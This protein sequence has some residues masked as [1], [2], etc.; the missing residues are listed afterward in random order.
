MVAYADLH[1]G[2]KGAV[3]FQYRKNAAVER[4]LACRNVY[5]TAL[6]IFA[7]GDFL[8]PRLDVFK[9]NSDVG[10]KLFPLGSQLHTSV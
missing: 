1:L 8:L 6:E 7:A 2:I 9:G 5:R 3:F 4:H 10:I